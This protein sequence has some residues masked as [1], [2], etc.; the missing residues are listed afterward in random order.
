MGSY[1]FIDEVAIAMQ[2]ARA[3]VHIKYSS[4][5]IILCIPFDSG[6]GSDVFAKSLVCVRE[7]NELSTRFFAVIVFVVVVLRLLL[8]NS[9]KKVGL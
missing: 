9:L 3:Y 2:N 8:F 4:N 1:V 5:Y 6:G 7:F